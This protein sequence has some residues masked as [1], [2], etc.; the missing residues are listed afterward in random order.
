MAKT[1]FQRR[2]QK[3]VA[4]LGELLSSQP[5]RFEFTWSR[6]V[7]GWVGEVH[8]RAHLQQRDS[9]SEVI[10]AIFGVLDQARKLARAV[11]AERHSGV[12]KSLVHLQHLCATAVATVTNPQLYR[13]QKDCTVRVRECCMTG[14]KG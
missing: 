14:E 1:A 4:E 2:F 10:P 9:V 12:K 13:F 7:D 6:L 3:R 8:R 5:E 11:G